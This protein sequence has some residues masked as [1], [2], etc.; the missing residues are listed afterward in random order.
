MSA[1][2]AKLEGQ[3]IEVSPQ[4]FIGRP[5]SDG[6]TGFVAKVHDDGSFDLQY[7][8]VER[9]VEKNVR[10]ERITSLNP[11]ATSARLLSSDDI[12]R[13]S[14]L[15]PSHH[16]AA[17]TSQPRVVLP[18]NV[19]NSPET[20]TG[21]TNIII[22]SRGWSEYERSPNPL[23]KILHDGN[24]KKKGW[25]RMDEGDYDRHEKGKQKGEMKAQLSP[26]ENHKLFALKSEIDRLH[27]VYQKQWPRPFTPI[28][29]LS[30][31]YGVSARKVRDHVVKHL[32]NGCNV[33]RKPRHNTCSA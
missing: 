20:A 6:G 5:N 15:A 19:P 29:S 1:S 4:T 3:L 14:L 9:R 31:A 22:E 12:Q 27:L 26:I 7:V 32:R 21:I 28:A 13:P 16:T 11:L 18:P 2:L 24:G 33:E 17:N 8:I 30:H 10:R 23:L 25:L